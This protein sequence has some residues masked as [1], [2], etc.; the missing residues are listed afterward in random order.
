MG[1]WSFLG[2]EKGACGKK[3]PEAGGLNLWSL[4]LHSLGWLLPNP[5]KEPRTFTYIC[6]HLHNFTYTLPSRLLSSS[7]GSQRSRLDLG[8]GDWQGQGLG[9]WECAWA[10]ALYPGRSALSYLGDSPSPGLAGAA[11]LALGWSLLLG[12]HRAPPFPCTPIT[13]LHTAVLVVGCLQQ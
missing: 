8:A 10:T 5:L 9:H 4:V 3:G 13:M 11:W 2:R 6:I 1:D 12:F 7:L